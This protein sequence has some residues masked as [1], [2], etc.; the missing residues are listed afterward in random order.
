MLSASAPQIHE[1]LN[2]TDIATDQIHEIVTAR[3]VIMMMIAIATTVT[4]TTCATATGIEIETTTAITII[5]DTNAQTRG[6]AAVRGT[7]ALTIENIRVTTVDKTDRTLAI[8]KETLTAT[9]PL[10]DTRSNHKFNPFHTATEFLL[11]STS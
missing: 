11:Q 2:E 5:T 7:T 9:D 8:A 3:A 6:I 4:T 10:T 1:H